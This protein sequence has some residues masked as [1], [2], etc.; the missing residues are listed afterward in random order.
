MEKPEEV[1]ATI[2]MRE[3]K[4]ELFFSV[5]SVLGTWSQ[6]G[7]LKPWGC[8]KKEDQLTSSDGCCVVCIDHP[9]RLSSPSSLLLFFLPHGM[10]SSQA[11]DQIW[12]S[13]VIYAAAAATP[14]LTQYARLRIKPVSRRCRDTINPLGQSCCA[15]AETPLSMFS[16]P[17]YYYFCFCLLSFLVVP[18]C[19]Q[20]LILL[21][22]VAAWVSPCGF[23]FHFTG[24]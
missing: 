12:A 4:G 14:V 15:T 1:L 16:D 18:H 6:G 10:W 23:S 11:R 20:H 5:D 2:S 17:N 3:M 9:R 21:N 19:D 8:A 7:G 24:S 13:V 22:L